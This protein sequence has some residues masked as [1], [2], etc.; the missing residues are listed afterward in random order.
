MDIF[1]LQNGGSKNLFLK[2]MFSSRE[3]LS[4]TLRVN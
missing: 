3:K 4:L 2:I 1:V